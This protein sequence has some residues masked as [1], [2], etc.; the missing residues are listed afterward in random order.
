MAAREER[1]FSCDGHHCLKI[2][3]GYL[4]ETSQP[5]AQATDAFPRNG[6]DPDQ[7]RMVARCPVLKPP[8]RNQ[9]QGRPQ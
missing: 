5:E 8:A 2:V 9:L 4:H 7:T 1:I 6:L 3:R